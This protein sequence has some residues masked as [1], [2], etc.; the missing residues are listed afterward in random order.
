MC[1]K[2]EEMCD[3]CR[4]KCS[5]IRKRWAG[6]CL[7]NLPAP[8]RCQALR[9]T[10][11]CRRS[12]D[13]ITQ[14]KALGAWSH[15]RMTHELAP[16]HR[17]DHCLFQL[18]GRFGCIHSTFYIQPARSL[19]SDCTDLGKSDQWFKVGFTSQTCPAACTVRSSSS[20]APKMNTTAEVSFTWLNL[21]HSPSIA[22]VCCNHS[23]FT[24]CPALGLIFCLLYMPCCK[25]RGF[26]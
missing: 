16:P 24:W 10:W 15:C 22:S 18:T 4:A 2:M 23:L 26:T 3:S 25:S 5:R 8:S 21:E 9:E 19:P 20:R 14:R 17:L 7:C 1:T 13:V 6:A 11:S 12:R